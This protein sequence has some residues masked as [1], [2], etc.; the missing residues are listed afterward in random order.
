MTVNFET[1][2]LKL[3]DFYIVDLISFSGG[4]SMTIELIVHCNSFKILPRLHTHLYIFSQ[5]NFQVTELQERITTKK[6]L[7]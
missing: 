5:N 1:L 6:F 3:T 7:K 2:I 4:L